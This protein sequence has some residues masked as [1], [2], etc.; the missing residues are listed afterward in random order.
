VILLG[1]ILA[2]FIAGV[3][4]MLRRS[5]YYNLDYNLDESMMNRANALLPGAGYKISD[6]TA[7]PGEKRAC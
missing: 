2:V 6:R 1:I 5:L 3:Y 4:L 7:N